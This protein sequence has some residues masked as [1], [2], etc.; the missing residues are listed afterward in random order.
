M[1][2]PPGIHFGGNMEYAKH[3]LQG[4]F[5]LG[6]SIKVVDIVVSDR[7]PVWEVLLSFHAWRLEG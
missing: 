6:P 5:G 1:E 4:D 7:G 2:Y 3:L